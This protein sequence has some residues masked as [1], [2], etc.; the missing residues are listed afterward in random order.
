MFV[1]FNKKMNE[2]EVDWLATKNSDWQVIGEEEGWRDGK[3]GREGKERLEII[4]IFPM[5]FHDNYAGFLY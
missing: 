3:E 5:F 4:S 2:N 1:N